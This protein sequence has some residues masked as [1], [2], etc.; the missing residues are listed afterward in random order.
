MSSAAEIL[1]SIGER[2]QSSGTVKNVFGDPIVAEGKTIVPVASVKYGF[3][4]GGGG[5]TTQDR[6]GGGGGGGMKTEPVGV[7]EITATG[8]R[9][10]YFIDPKRLALTIAAGFML[11]MMF[12]RLGR[13]RRRG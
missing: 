8:T 7:L 11:G 13:R 12:S 6:A 3:G 2:L 9:F 10:I 1:Q 4:A 5:S